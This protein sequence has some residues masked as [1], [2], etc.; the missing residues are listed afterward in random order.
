MTDPYVYLIHEGDWNSDA[1]LPGASEF[2][3]PS[4]IR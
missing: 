2:Q 1:Y 4:W 3:S